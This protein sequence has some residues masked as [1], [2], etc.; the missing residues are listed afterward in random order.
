MVEW[1]R[2]SCCILAIWLGCQATRLLPAEH[3][4]SAEIVVLILVVLGVMVLSGRW[5]RAEQIKFA[6]R[7]SRYRTA[8]E[9]R[10]KAECEV[11]HY[12]QWAELAQLYASERV[13]RESVEAAR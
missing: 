2:V 6:E 4:R 8:I 5:V 9:K 12:G 10:V 11:S 3:A 1:V 7:L 13:A